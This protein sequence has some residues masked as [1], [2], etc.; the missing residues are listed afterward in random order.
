MDVQSDYSDYSYWYDVLSGYGSYIVD[1]DG[2]LI[3]PAQYIKGQDG[4]KMWSN[5]LR[6]SSPRDQRFVSW[7]GC[8]PRP[9]STRSSSASHD[10]RLRRFHFGDRLARHALADPAD[11]YRH[12]YA[13]FGEVYY[14]ITDN[15][16]A[17]LGLRLFSTDNSLKG[18]FGFNYPG[19][20]RNGRAA[21]LQR[22]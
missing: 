18:F 16:T 6:L 5:E 15:F 10:R 11:A 7:P 9:Q 1:N 4:Y 21:V 14:D 22:Q 13:A 2:Q 8:S 3:N 12:S 19:F 20:K 17:T